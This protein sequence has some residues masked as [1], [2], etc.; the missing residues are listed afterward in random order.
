MLRIIGLCL[1]CF[2]LLWHYLPRLVALRAS[3]TR[4]K[5]DPETGNDPLV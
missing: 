3:V 1:L 4:E 5:L 2:G